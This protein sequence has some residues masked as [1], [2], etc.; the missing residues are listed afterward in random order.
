MSPLHPNVSSIT[1]NHIKNSYQAVTCPTIRLF[2]PTRPARFQPGSS[3]ARDCPPQPLG[4]LVL[5]SGDLWENRLC[6]FGWD[7]GYPSKTT[8]N[9]V[10]WSRTCLL[11]LV[12]SSFL[13]EFSGFFAT[14]V[15]SLINWKLLSLPSLLGLSDFFFLG[16]C[17]K[18]RTQTNKQ[19]NKLT[20]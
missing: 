2:D 18:H 17:E 5:S 13:G 1:I 14:L 12:S 9:Q 8:G 15:L 19:T 11:K 7:R 6:L 16:S 4:P 10:M 3:A 20:N